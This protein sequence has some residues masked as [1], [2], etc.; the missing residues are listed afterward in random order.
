MVRDEA[1]A[2]GCAA[3]KFTMMQQGQQLKVENISMNK[4]KVHLNIW[5]S[6]F[7]D[8]KKATI[9][10]CNYSRGNPVKGAKVYMAGP[11]ASS[12][13]SGTNSKY[14][15]LCSENEQIEEPNIQW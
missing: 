15:G 10:T 1:R 4:I 8:L 11:T 5:D 7:S 14:P 12:C 13:K 3:S 2:V 9:M 6:D